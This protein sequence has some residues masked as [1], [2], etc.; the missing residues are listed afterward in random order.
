M[1]KSIYIESF[2]AIKDKEIN[3]DDGLNI[4]YGENETGKST[5]CAFIKAMLYGMDNSRKADIRSVARKR[6]MPIDAN[7]MSGSMTV[8]NYKITA[9]FGKTSK[10]DVMTV[11]DLITGEIVDECVGKKILG[12]AEQT[13][14]NLLFIESYNP[15]LSS[16]DE[17]VSRIANL[18]DNGDENISYNKAIDAL[19]AAKRKITGRTGIAVLEDELACIRNS[20]SVAEDNY[21]DYQND[22]KQLNKFR[23]DELRL[24]ER[25]NY[26][27][28]LIEKFNICRKY[29]KMRELQNECDMLKK[30]IEN[31]EDIAAEKEAFPTADE[32]RE[33]AQNSDDSNKSKHYLIASV[34][35]LLLGLVGIGGIA[36]KPL[37]IML[38]LLIPSALLY[39]KAVSERNKEYRE[40]ENTLS[41]FYKQFGVDNID[42]YETEYNLRKE[43]RASSLLNLQGMFKSKYEILAEYEEELA[44]AEVDEQITDFYN[45]KDIRSEYDA[46]TSQISNVQKE[47][48]VLE[49]K[50]QREPLSP[51]SY[52][53]Q[54]EIKENE[55]NKMRDDWVCLQIAS[56]VLEESFVQ[57][58]SGLAPILNK[59]V[60]EIFSYITNSKYDNVAV[61][62]G[63]DLSLNLKNSIISSPYLSNGTLD[64]VYTA[65][66]LAIWEII[67]DSED[68]FLIL[69]DAFIQYD[70]KRAERAMEYLKS[71][72]KQI[73]YFTCQKRFDKNIDLIQ[74]M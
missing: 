11:I 69:D 26:L 56:E 30:E 2:G 72:N 13:F 28:I 22:V 15:K 17:I 53:R 1:I 25:K 46:V 57:L 5:I 54:F 10:E 67:F 6:Y 12:V 63:F 9:V 64:A 39:K 14:S 65:L 60:G 38:V 18:K 51:E 16:D 74:K 23:N 19:N 50:T 66:K 4:I 59:R 41:R 34:V 70:D 71:L 7:R 43:R 24:S 21:N 42:D 62:S 20:L 36:A 68:S 31:F 3:F 55:L 47:I 44:G 48:L 8:S 35:M 37:L 32:L 49:C 33:I 29:H 61:T 40:T 27:E 58:Q 52:Y 45:E 73:L